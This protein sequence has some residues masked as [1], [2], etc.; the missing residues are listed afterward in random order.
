MN[1]N[2]TSCSVCKKGY[3]LGKI[4][5]C[6]LVDALCVSYNTEDYSCSECMQ[7]LKY[8]G[9]ICSTWFIIYFCNIKYY[10]VYLNQWN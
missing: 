2:N 6:G 1:A 8:N 10:F 3:L 4:G 7:G 9:I 5:V